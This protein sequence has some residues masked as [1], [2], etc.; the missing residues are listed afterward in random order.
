MPL[1]AR[2]PRRGGA[3]LPNERARRP[4]FAT[5]P[6]LVACLI[7]CVGI[8]VG[9]AGTEGYDP[10]TWS[11]D[12]A[13]HI[14]IPPSARLEEVY[15]HTPDGSTV[16][17]ETVPFTE[18]LPP[19]SILIDASERRLYFVL[20]NGRALRYVVGVGREGFAWSGRDRISAKR[21]WPDWIPPVEMRR[22]EAAAGR[23]LP[24]RVSGGPDNPLGARAL[25]IGNTLYRIHGTNQPWTVGRANSSGCIRM[26]NADVIDL[27]DRVTTGALVVVRH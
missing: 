9:R 1:A 3:R 25:Y 13:H 19:G 2:L 14:V 24:A 22:R 17:R 15:G 10:R 11:Y 27:Y 26:T 18:P 20:G 7:A 23:L 12:P 4:R 16:T 5:I 8:G 21:M 6:L